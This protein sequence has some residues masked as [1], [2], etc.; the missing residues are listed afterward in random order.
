MGAD[1]EGTLERLKARRHE[2]LDPIIAEHRGRIVKT[3]GDGMCRIQLS[4]L[5]PIFATKAVDPGELPFI[6]GNDGIAECDCPCGNEQIVAA[7]RST[8]LFEPGADQGIGGIGRCLEGEYFQ[9]AKYRFQLRRQSWRP[10]LTSAVAP[11]R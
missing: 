6:V 5:E 7:D 2:L 9:P 11:F 1:E 10:S 8:D 4:W 3:T